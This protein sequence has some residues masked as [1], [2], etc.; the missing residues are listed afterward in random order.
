MEEKKALNLKIIEAT[1]D[2]MKREGLEC[3]FVIFYG[4]VV[5]TC[6]DWRETFLKE[7]LDKRSIPYVDTKA[8]IHAY[9]MRTNTLPDAL[10]T[11]V[12]GTTTTSGTR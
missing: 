11:P 6:V 10:Y 8:V 12:D 5:M 9:C 1:Q 2:I 4:P 3:V 7:A